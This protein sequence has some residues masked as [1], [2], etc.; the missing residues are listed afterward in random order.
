MCDLSQSD[1]QHE[2]PGGNCKGPGAAHRSAGLGNIRRLDA[3]QCAQR[4]AAAGQPRSGGR[5]ES[6]RCESREG[7][8]LECHN[9]VWFEKEMMCLSETLLKMNSSLYLFKGVKVYQ[10]RV[11]EMFF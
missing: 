7:Q 3:A 1:G 9:L 8:W 5:D 4:H 6:S 11:L 10:G 2:A